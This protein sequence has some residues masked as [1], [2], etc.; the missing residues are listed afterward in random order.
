[1]FILILIFGLVTSLIFMILKDTSY[2][3]YVLQK[4][5]LSSKTISCFSN[6]IHGTALEIIGLLF[7]QS[8]CLYCHSIFFFTLSMEEVY[9]PNMTLKL[10]QING[11]GVMNMAIWS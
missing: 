10:L 4:N 9:E 1:M 6:I 11:I 7:L 8:F 5:L 2:I 3:G